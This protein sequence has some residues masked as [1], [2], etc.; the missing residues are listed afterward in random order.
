MRRHLVVYAAHLERTKTQ[1][2]F[3]VFEVMTPVFENFETLKTL[4]P[5][6]NQVLYWAWILRQVS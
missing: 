3:I 1:V 2:L 6:A 5:S 4:R